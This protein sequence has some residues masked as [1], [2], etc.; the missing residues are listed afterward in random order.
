MDRS[1]WM[2][3]QYVVTSWEPV[4]ALSMSDEGYDFAGWFNANHH[5]LE[6]DE[7]A[8]ALG[9]MFQ[10]GDIVARW[11]SRDGPDFLPTR[12]QIEHALDVV[13]PPKEALF[14]YGL[15]TQGARRWEEAAR[16]NWS[17]FISACWLADPEPNGINEVICLDRSRAEQFLLHIEG[18]EIVS[19]QWE[20]LSPSH[21]LFCVYINRGCA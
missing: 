12:A 15:T 7:L 2:L 4:A 1:R 10:D 11:S 16:P 19:P 5:G 8:D 21:D 17:R 9:A 18:C 3:L 13:H 6:Q 20:L 14:D